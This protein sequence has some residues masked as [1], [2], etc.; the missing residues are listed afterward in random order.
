MH[1]YYI[2]LVE[3]K[4]KGNLSPIQ[5][6]HPQSVNRKSK[7]A[8]EIFSLYFKTIKTI[9]SKVGISHFP[10]GIKRKLILNQHGHITDKIRKLL[11]YFWKKLSNLPIFE[12]NLLPSDRKQRSDK[13]F[14]HPRCFFFKHLSHNFLTNGLGDFQFCTKNSFFDENCKTMSLRWRFSNPRSNFLNNNFPRESPGKTEQNSS[15]QL[16]VC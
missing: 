4:R 9:K 12:F 1:Y 5:H 14:A 7:T 8:C 10:W 16:C 3:R 6:S 15:F 11:W 13:D 2:Y